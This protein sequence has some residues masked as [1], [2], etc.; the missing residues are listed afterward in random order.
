[1]PAIVKTK[2]YRNTDS[3]FLH[4]FGI[5]GKESTN[6]SIRYSLDVLTL[7]AMLRAANAVLPS[8]QLNEMDIKH[9]QYGHTKFSDKRFM[10]VRTRMAQESM[11][12]KADRGF[13][14]SST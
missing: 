1:M 13:N 9:Q 11:I 5:V 12:K 6:C 8:K 10:E 3:R 4:K 14:Q 2:F 7:L